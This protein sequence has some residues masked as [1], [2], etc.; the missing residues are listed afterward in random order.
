[1]GTGI[2][3]AMIL[4]AIIG[5]GTSFYA[6]EKQEDAAKQQR[7]DLAKAE[8][9][10]QKEIDRIASQTRP[11]EESSK[12]ITFGSNDDELGNV[13]DFIVDRPE[14]LK[15]GTANNNGM[16]QLGFNL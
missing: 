16:S 11:E 15:L 5:A 7:K 12:S 14:G 9:E 4:S 6:R 8:D 13:G 1:M 3:E 10:R 2:G